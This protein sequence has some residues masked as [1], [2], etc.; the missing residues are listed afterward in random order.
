M[1]NNFTVP[2][3]A[4]QFLLFY[5][6]IEVYPSIFN[7]NLTYANVHYTIDSKNNIYNT[8]NSWHKLFNT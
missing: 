8:K 5:L 7:I 1:K 2:N 6:S 4:L 3:H